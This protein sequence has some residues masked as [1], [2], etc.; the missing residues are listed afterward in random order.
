MEFI[1]EAGDF[2][3]ETEKAVLFCAERKD[4]ILLKCIGLIAGKSGLKIRAFNRVIFYKSNFESVDVKQHGECYIPGQMLFTIMQTIPKDFQLR[5]KTNDK[6]SRIAI[7]SENSKEEI[8]YNIGLIDG[9]FALPKLRKMKWFNL[10]PKEVGDAINKCV[11][12]VAM[13]AFQKVFQ[14]INFSFS[15]GQ[16]CIVATNTQTLIYNKIS[17]DKE[18]D[19]VSCTIPG[20]K[21]SLLS[22]IL[23]NVEE[24]KMGISMEDKHARHSYFKTDN[25]TSIATLMNV[26]Y[27][28]VITKIEQRLKKIKAKE[29]VVNRKDFILAV[30]GVLIAEDTKDISLTSNGEYLIL[31]SFEE[32][33]A[34]ALRTIP[35]ISG[36]KWPRVVNFDGEDFLR[37]MEIV[38]AGCETVNMIY[39]KQLF[40]LK[41]NSDHSSF[42]CYVSPMVSG[43]T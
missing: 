31:K 19:L 42:V 24:F 41:I 17:H 3:E 39:H 9:S 11:L 4:D 6:N 12:A 29:I 25:S 20:I 16:L 32:Q 22:K 13:D 35:L 10:D 40:P 28:D 18:K 23:E 34:D 15:G 26:N 7:T 43:K 30:K 14:G 2:C 1:I 5:F 38:Y 27:P 37:I 21:L 36:G 8:K 33:Q